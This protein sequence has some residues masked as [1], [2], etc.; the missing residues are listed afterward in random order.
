MFL[1][2]NISGSSIKRSLCWQRIN[3]RKFK[4]LVLPAFYIECIHQ[5]RSIVCINLLHY[6]ELILSVLLFVFI[7]NKLLISQKFI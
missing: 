6:F 7:F 4:F 1:P 5:S 3:E 2:S